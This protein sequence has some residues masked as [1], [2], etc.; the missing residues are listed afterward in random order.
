M[1]GL[2]NGSGAEWTPP[3]NRRIDRPKS[4]LTFP[5]P[6]LFPPI[7]AEQKLYSHVDWSKWKF[8]LDEDEEEEEEEEEVRAC[9]VRCGAVW[10]DVM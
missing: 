3:S 10:C 1:V 6:H 8:H 4:A 2:S 5:P 9:S 7:Y